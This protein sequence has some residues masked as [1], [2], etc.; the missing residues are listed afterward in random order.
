MWATT[1]EIIPD[2]KD[3]PYKFEAHKFGKRLLKHWEYCSSCGLIAFNNDPTRRS[4]KLGCNY[5][6]MPL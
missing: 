3:I 1:S 5:Q 4:I 6:K 2:D